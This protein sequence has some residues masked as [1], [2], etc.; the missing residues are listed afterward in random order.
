MID[1]LDRIIARLFKQGFSPPG[2][3][4]TRPSDLWRELCAMD[5]PPWEEEATWLTQCFAVGVVFFWLVRRFERWMATPE[6]DEVR[7]YREYLAAEN[8]EKEE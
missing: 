5:W 4:E 1:W 2:E 3:G 6:S 7:M 8:G